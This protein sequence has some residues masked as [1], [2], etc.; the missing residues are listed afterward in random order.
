MNCLEQE[1]QVMA[2]LREQERLVHNE[3][4]D[5]L[6][7]IIT[8]RVRPLFSDHSFQGQMYKVLKD[9][10][11]CPEAMFALAVMNTDYFKKVKNHNPFTTVMVASFPSWIQA[12]ESIS[13]WQQVNADDLDLSSNE[14]FISSLY[15]AGYIT[16]SE[17]ERIQRCYEKLFAPS[18]IDDDINR[19]I[20]RVEYHL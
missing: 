2:D 20:Q 19:L 7:T 12:V 10:V 5:S 3:F 6:N 15:R 17:R 11:E 8:T 13:Y 9:S 4:V 1:K 14:A 16:S 18:L